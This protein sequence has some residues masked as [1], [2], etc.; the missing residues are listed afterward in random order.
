MSCI[1]LT[2]ELGSAFS[3]ILKIIGIAYCGFMIYAVIERIY[4][5]VIVLTL[6]MAILYFKFLRRLFFSKKIEYSTN[7]IKIDGKEK[8]IEEISELGEGFLLLKEDS[9]KK[10]YFNHY[11]SH[12]RL[13][14]L[15]NILDKE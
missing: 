5:A 3:I 11:F 6:L 9:S 14:E 8:E 7:K 2:T 1:S 10:I 4:G 13:N 15:R 12:N